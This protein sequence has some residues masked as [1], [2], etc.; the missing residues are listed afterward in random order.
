MLLEV[1]VCGM[2]EGGQTC[3][4]ARGA[5]HGKFSAVHIESNI[6]GEWCDNSSGDPTLLSAIQL[7]DLAIVVKGVQRLTCSINQRYKAI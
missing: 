5:H 2:G 7:Q 3:V 1:C 6:C 4:S